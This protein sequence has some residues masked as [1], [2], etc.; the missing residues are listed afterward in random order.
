VLSCATCLHPFSSFSSSILGPYY[1]FQFRIGRIGRTPW[2][3]AQSSAGP[4]LSRRYLI[5]NCLFRGCV[6]RKLMSMTWRYFA[7]KFYQSYFRCGW[8]TDKNCKSFDILPYF[9]A[10]MAVTS[11]MPLI[12]AFWKSKPLVRPVWVRL[13]DICNSECLV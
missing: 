5:W 13:F 3:G 2:M 6:S 9:I 11:T 7:W 4:I 10:I 8:V 12:P 1:L